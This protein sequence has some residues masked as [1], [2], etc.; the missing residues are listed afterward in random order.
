MVMSAD[1]GE[2]P[3]YFKCELEPEG[4]SVLIIIFQSV[5]LF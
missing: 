3:S 2:T 1:Q 5:C 4:V